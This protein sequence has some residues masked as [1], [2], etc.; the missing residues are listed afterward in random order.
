MSIHAP[1]SINSPIF[2]PTYFT[3]ESTASLTQSNADSRY[4]RLSGGTETGGVNFQS[5]IN[6]NSSDLTVNT[7]LLKTDYQNSRVGIGTDSP[8]YTL[9]VAGNVWGSN[10]TANGTVFTNTVSAT[11][12]TVGGV[13]TPY[14]TAITPA[15]GQLGY[16]NRSFIG[17]DF[18]VS[19]GS[20]QNVHS[21]TLAVG[22]WLIIA[23][24]RPY[25]STN[26]TTSTVS[27]NVLGWGI[28]SAN[29]VINSFNVSNVYRYSALKDLLGTASFT[30]ANA[31]IL[32][33]SHTLNLTA[34][35][36]LYLNAQMAFTNGAVK[37]YAT[38]T[39]FIYTRIA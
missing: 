18:T 37:Y 28:Y 4:L 22:T 8:N 19:S 29:N 2:N 21:V 34:S 7:S 13:I 17:S 3:A 30:N 11:N 10:L 1:P 14:S 39:G 6:V 36:T 24:I 12:I 15:E 27:G 9:H 31:P 20:I 26:G 23:S 5:G 38:N 35:T 25:N 16:T 33:I 32:Q